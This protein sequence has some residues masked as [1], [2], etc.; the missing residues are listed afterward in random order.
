MPEPQLLIAPRS[1]LPFSLAALP[2]VVLLAVFAA[3]ALF[4][5]L[6]GSL[7]IIAILLAAIVAGL[8]GFSHGISWQQMEQAAVAKFG[9]VF[10][11]VLILLSI[12][13]LIGSWM[14]CGTIPFF[15]WT[16]ITLI[17]P[18]YLYISAFLAAA[19]MSL[20]T[21]SSWASAGTIGVALMGLATVMDASLPVTAGAV[22]S[23]ACFGDKMSPLSD[24]TNI[25]AIAAKADL[26]QHIGH[27]IYTAVPSFILA[28]MVFWLVPASSNT[29]QNSALAATAAMQTLIETTFSPDWWQLLPPALVIFAIVKKWPPVVGITYSTLLALTLA[30]L[31]LPFGTEDAITAYLNGFSTDMLPASLQ[32]QASANPAFIQL[33]ERGG[34]Y[35]MVSTLVVIIAAFLLAGTMQASGA[36]NVLIQAMLRRVKGVFSLVLSTMVSGITLLSL[37]SHGGVTSLIVGNLYQQGYKARGLAAVNLSRS[38]EDSVTLMDPVLPWTVSG[39]FMAATLGVATIEYLPWTVFCLGGPLFSLLVAG[40]FSHT[41]AIRLVNQ[42]A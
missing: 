32:Q 15:V 11:V 1:P 35:S 12:G 6:G 34:L 31:L 20:F 2:L 39:L 13:G 27:M 16:G 36:L 42:S 9:D 23:G 25:S 8:I 40:F 19:I 7:V 21:G 29:D 37:T 28:L 5:D 24:S 41:R 33:V 18:D 17:N 38:I 10:P 14:L 26:Y 30:V 3:G 4:S 22:I